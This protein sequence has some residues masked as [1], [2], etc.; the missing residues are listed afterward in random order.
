M[1]KHPLQALMAVLLAS[2]LAACNTTPPMEANTDF[3]NRFDFSSVK[4]IVIEPA[5]RMDPAMIRISD[6]QIGRIS[7]AMADQLVRRGYVIVQ[8]R[9]EA[10]M[11]LIWHLVTQEKLDVRSYNSAGYYNCWGCGPGVSDVSVRQFTQGTLI[12]DMI[13]PQRNKSVWRSIVETRLR[14][15]PSQQEASERRAEAA[16]ALFADFPPQ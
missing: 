3:D 7:D 2:L 13:D 9:S 6:M 1:M 10:D 8:Q 14:S 16:R 5:S 11:F 4:K 15:Q 12:V